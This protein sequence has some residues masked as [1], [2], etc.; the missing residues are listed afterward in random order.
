MVDLQAKFGLKSLPVSQDPSDALGRVLLLDGDGS[1]YKAATT[2]KKLETCMRRFEVFILEYMFLA[3]CSSAR[4]HLTPSGCF[5]NGR[6]LLKGVKPYQGN[7]SGK[8]KPPLLEPIRSYASEYFK[9]H[10]D[11]TIIQNFDIEADDGLMID[12]YRMDN[13]VLVS[14]DKDLQISPFESYDINTGKFKVLN[15]GDR[16]GYLEEHY[17]PSGTLKVKGKGTAFFF[18]QMLMGDTADNVAG[19]Q[20]L[21]NKLC[22]ARAALNALKDCTNEE[23]AV[24]VV[25]DGYRAINQNPL[26]EAEA[27][28]LLRNREDSAL[29]FLQETGLSA[30][31]LDFLL[32][33]NEEDWKD[34][35]VH[36]SGDSADCSEST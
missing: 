12:H 16:Y 9:N 18:A 23:E 2:A 21:N 17:T 30:T 5:K 27:L 1:A 20:K 11:I 31:N 15:Q 24:G 22:G 32:T 10:P 19:L 14:E 35:N 6:H 8:A 13:G 3:K 29:K 7:R 33:K 34:T 36:H 28:W 26:P 4:V 25:L